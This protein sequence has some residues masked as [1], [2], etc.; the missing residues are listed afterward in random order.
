MTNMYPE[1]MTWNPLGG[2]CSHACE[3]CY[4]EDMM[5]FPAV[6][7][8]YTGKPYIALHEPLRKTDK[9]VFVC[10]MTDL[11]AEDVPNS[12]IKHILKKCRDIPSNTYLFQSKNPGRVFEYI[13]R[14]PRKS[15]VGTTLES[16][17][18]NLVNRSP[19]APT[20][21]DR[22]HGM[23]LLKE[24]NPRLLRMVSIEPI[25]DFDTGIFPNMLSRMDLA[26]VSI[27]ADS[28]NKGLPEPS[29]DKIE[30]L[31]SDLDQFTEVRIK[32]NL[33]RLRNADTG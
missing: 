5:R 6:K 30:R 19:N 26:Y 24:E 14:L 17:R 2:E 11:F 10:S 29:A 18:A 13:Y 27:G 9:V 28:K 16:N 12:M 15:I 3:Y 32:S 31:I 1:T 8:K 25:M 33:A 23:L 7:E 21:L 22:I 20:A 4:R